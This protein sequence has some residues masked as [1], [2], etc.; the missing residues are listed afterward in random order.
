MPEKEG[1][2]W[3]VH[4]PALVSPGRGVLLGVLRGGGLEASE[5]PAGLPGEAWGQG[6]REESFWLLPQ[7][8]AAGSGVGLGG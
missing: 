8:S 2:L 3:P 4:P 7:T 1:P 5:S 6:W